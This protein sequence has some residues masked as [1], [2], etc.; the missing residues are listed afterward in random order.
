MLEAIEERRSIR[1]YTERPVEEEKLMRILNSGRLAPSDTNTQPWNFI[2]VRSEDMRRKLAEVSHKQKWMLSAPVFI[3]CVADIRA[4]VQNEA[5]IEI[6]E[7]T[8]GYAVKQIILDTAIAAENMVLAAQSLGL[9]T[10]WVTW[11]TQNEIRP[12]LDVPKDKYVVCI[13]TLGYANEA[14]NA[15]PRRPLEEIIRYEK[16]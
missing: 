13:I 9:G 10:C 7:D 14:P 6:D 11:F 16:W 8:S 2:V 5:E 12:L 15:R 4:A 3:V 1:K